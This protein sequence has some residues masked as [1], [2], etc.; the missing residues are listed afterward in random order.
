MARDI[1]KDLSEM[2][3]GGKEYPGE[4]YRLAGILALIAQAAVEMG[5]PWGLNSYEESFC[6]LCTSTM[7]NDASTMVNDDWVIIH[8]PDCPWQR[9]QEL[10]KEYEA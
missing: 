3:E 5:S 7:V 6:P 10:K 2:V 1:K 4:T 9:I 8:N